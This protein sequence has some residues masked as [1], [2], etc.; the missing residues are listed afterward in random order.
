M[1]AVVVLTLVPASRASAQSGPFWDVPDGKYYTRPIAELEKM[2]VFEG[3]ACGEGLFCPDDPV[4]RWE[5]A[6][7][8]VRVVDGTDPGQVPATRFHDVAQEVWWAPYTERMYQLGITT[9]CG[10]GTNFCPHAPVRRSH[11]AAFLTRAFDLTPGP[12]PGFADVAPENWYHD[13]VIALARS[14]ITSGCGRDYFCADDHTSRAQM[15]T[16]LHRAI[17]RDGTQTPSCKFA[18]HADRVTSAVFQVHSGGLGTAFR[19]GSLYFD[20]D[21]RLGKDEWWEE[22][23]TAAHVIGDRRQVTLT[24]GGVSLDAEVVGIDLAY[25]V[26]LLRTKTL[27]DIRREPLRYGKAVWLEPGADLY[28]VG[29]PLHTASQPTVSKGVL[30]RIEEDASLARTV[31]SKGTLILTDAP[32]NPGNSGGPLVDACGSVIGMNVA[33]VAAVD[34]EG[35]NWAIAETTLQER[36]SALE[37]G[38]GLVTTEQTGE[39]VPDATPPAATGLWEYFD[40][41]GLWGNY[42]GYLLPEDDYKSYLV[43]RCAVDS[44]VDAAPDKYD[45]VFFSTSHFISNDPDY[46]AANVSYRFSNDA[47]ITVDTEFHS[48]EQTESAIFARQ[49]F[50]DTLSEMTAEALYFEVILDNGDTLLLSF[51]LAGLDAVVASL[52]CI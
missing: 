15:A 48:N 1:V 2:G 37:R 8:I 46:Y 21:E 16:F 51:K 11:M 18:D 17:H 20:G 9:G 13:H 32:I 12:H 26:A 6:V 29:Y 7:W 38:K 28:A 4:L 23:L 25:D 45:G 24:S 31:V 43:I 5:M 22:W 35:I 30:S 42:E 19:V 39:P 52:D 3:T 47:L 33:G 40:G 14:G 27:W 36:Y 41:S 44:L 50:I 49:S 10:D 34:V